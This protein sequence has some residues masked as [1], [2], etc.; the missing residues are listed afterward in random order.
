MM[1][2]NSRRRQHYPKYGPKPDE[3]NS[4]VDDLKNELNGISRF[5]EYGPEKYAPENGSAKKLAK[6]FAT[7]FKVHPTQ[8]RNFF[9]SIKK[10]QRTLKNNQWKEVRGDFMMLQ[11][12]MAYSV[13]RKDSK[14]KSLL[15]KTFYEMM[16]MCMSK[17]DDGKTDKEDREL[18]EDFENFA[19]FFEAI[20]AYHRYYHPN[21]Q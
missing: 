10:I 12:H 9:Q 8:I 18:K 5:S 13:G 11:P 15:N 2:D 4:D 7:T 20:V 1:R 3:K 17:V 21:E 14:N 16:T 6:S 19:N